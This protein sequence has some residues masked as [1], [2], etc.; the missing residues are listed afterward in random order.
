MKYIVTIMVCLLA[1]ALAHAQPIVTESTSNAKTKVESP[2]PSAISPNI[3][4]INNLMCS[5]GVSAAIQTQILGISTGTT[6]TDLNCEMVILSRELY[7]QQ[8]KAPATTLLCQDARVWWSLWDSGVYC[9]VEGKFGLNAKEYWEA[10]QTL[11]P[12]RPKVK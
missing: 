11:I 2:P 10:N 5:S 12:K 1:V 9:P 3:T 6:I 8:M 7:S 4:N